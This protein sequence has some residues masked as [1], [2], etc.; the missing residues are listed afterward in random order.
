LVCPGQIVH[1]VCLD[2]GWMLRLRYL[3]QMAYEESRNGTG[4]QLLTPW[5]G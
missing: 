1:P 5:T 4:A 3:F 2:E